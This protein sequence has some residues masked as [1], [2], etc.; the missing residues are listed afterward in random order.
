MLIDVVLLDDLVSH[1]HPQW[2]HGMR[3]GIMIGTNHLVE[4]IHHIL[5]KVHHLYIISAPISL[6]LY[7][8]LFILI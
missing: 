1:G 8:I 3:K 2:L 4:V 7:D 5:F 6:P